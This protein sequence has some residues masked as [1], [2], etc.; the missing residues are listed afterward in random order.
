MTDEL[1]PE[2]DPSTLPSVPTAGSYRPELDY[3]S[4]NYK[5]FGVP[6]G[7]KKL[8]GTEQRKWPGEHFCDRCVHYYKSLKA[9]GII[10]QW[11]MVCQWDKATHFSKIPQETRDQMTV[12][13]QAIVEQSMDPVIWTRDVLN[14]DADWYQAEMLR[15]S[16]QFKVVRGGRRLGKSETMCRDM[17]HKA[18]TK[19]GRDGKYTLLVLCPYEAQVKMVF[20]NLLSII[21]ASSFLSSSVEGHTKNP[22]EIRFH[23]GTRIRA[24]SVGRK[25]GARSDK[26]RGQGA[27]DIYFD[28]ADYMADEDIEVIFAVLA[29]KPDTSIW[30]SSTP[31]G[32]R[33]KY[34]MLCVDKQQG[35]KEFHYVSSESP[36]WTPKVEEMLRAVYSVGGYDREFNAEFGTPTAGVFRPDDLDECV[37]DYTYES[38]K[39]NP[40]YHYTIGVDWNKTT[41]THLIVLEAG[42]G[43]NGPFYRVVEKQI[44]RKSEFTQ[45][46][47]VMAVIALDQKW[48]ADYIYVD[49]GYGGTNIEMLWKYDRDHPQKRL[50]FQKR[51][52]SVHGNEMVEIPDPRN[53]AEIIRK[54]SKPFMIDVV[55]KWVEHH[56]ISFPKH[57][58]TQTPIIESEVQ[59]ANIGLVQQMRSFKVE[60]LSPEGRPRYSQGYEHTFMALCFAAYAMVRGF[61]ELWQQTQLAMSIRM[62]ATAFGQLVSKQAPGPTDHD[63]ASSE[64]EHA[65]K[66]KENPIIVKARELAPGRVIPGDGKP[67]TQRDSLATVG[68]R[69]PVSPGRWLGS[70]M[71]IPRR[72]IP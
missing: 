72:T 26:V 57:E 50:N 29:D 48:K 5:P 38:I 54:P 62:R 44:I 59:F 24:F 1:N 69:K 14:W 58:D 8:D 64:Q 32:A 41:G 7:F 56:L 66:A 2:I 45:H 65:M 71:S 55:A 11:P 67:A 15:C 37:K 27:D 61:S 68:L 40:K 70:G 53:A 49:E 6:T 21:S 42:T 16:S 52:R 20:D 22:W 18:C 12:E 33:S 4:R 13:E 43:K 3:E 36:R 23:N 51:L 19:K 10:Q 30:L 63:A 34:W 60:K 28:E 31:T 39:R 35:F 46:E 25:S 9:D 47:G 17:L